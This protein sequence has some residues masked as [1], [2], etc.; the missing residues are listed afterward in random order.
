MCE[1]K[2]PDESDTD[3]SELQRGSNMAKS[4]RKL[5]NPAQIG[6]SSEQSALKSL[7]FS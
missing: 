2:A 5:A 1:S 3:G 6:G 4:L 7:S